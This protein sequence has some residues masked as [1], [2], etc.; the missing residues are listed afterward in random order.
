MKLLLIFNHNRIIGGGEISFARY[1]NHIS[2]R[3]DLEVSV[4]IPS[5]GDLEKHLKIDKT[6]IISFEIPSFKSNPKKVVECVVNFYKIFKALKPDIVHANG[7]RVALYSN[8]AKIFTNTK[9]IWHVRITEKDLLDLILVPT[10]DGIIAN[11]KRTLE[12]RFSWLTENKRGKKIKV[13]Y[14]GFDISE[15][16]DRLKKAVSSIHKYQDHIV[17][18]SAGRLELGKGFE[19]LL[20][21]AEILSYREKIQLVLAGTG[22]LEDKFKEIPKNLKAV[23]PGYVPIENILKVSD[24]ICFPSLVDSFGNL[25]VESMIAGRLCMVSEKSGA[26]EIYPIDALKFNPKSFKSFSRSF[27]YAKENIYNSELSQNLQGE[28]E[29]FSIDRHSESVLEYYRTIACR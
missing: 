13:I 2:R 27:Y 19:Y 28:A 16:R 22:P 18:G 17:I 25:V 24:I 5:G 21:F 12:K 10:S 23:F 8:I 7:S 14:N 20:N 3:K 6:K 15:I 29:K 11:S 26:S 9:T 1:I 4:F